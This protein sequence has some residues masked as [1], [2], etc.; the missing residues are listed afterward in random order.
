[1]ADCHTAAIVL[2]AAIGKVFSDGRHLPPEL[3]GTVRT[4]ENAH[5]VADAVT[6]GGS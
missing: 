1:M 3:A 5:A 4:Q 6:A 2:S